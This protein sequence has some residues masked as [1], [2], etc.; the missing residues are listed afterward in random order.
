MCLGRKAQQI[1]DSAVLIAFLGRFRAIEHEDDSFFLIFLKITFVAFVAFCSETI[2]T[3]VRSFAR[4]CFSS[5]CCAR[6]FFLLL[7]SVFLRQPLQF[8]KYK[9]ISPKYV[10]GSH[11][12][13]TWELNYGYPGVISRC[14]YGWLYQRIIK[15]F[16]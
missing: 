13:S 12:T 16:A 5:A 7:N 11:S 8:E 4:T 1:H 15:C 10:C 3:P 9:A 14:E 6:I 2:L